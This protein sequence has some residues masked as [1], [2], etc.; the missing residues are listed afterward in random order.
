MSKKKV[1]V[2]G[3]ALRPPIGKE[4]I[5]ELISGTDHVRNIK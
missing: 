5:L 3:K 4:T 1:V 2:E